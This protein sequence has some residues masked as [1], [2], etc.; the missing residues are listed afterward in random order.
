VNGDKDFT[1]VSPQFTV[2]Y[3]VA[4]GQTV[5]GTAA[6][7][8]KAG[9]FNAASPAGSEGYGEEHSWNYEGGFKS[10]WLGQRLALNGAVFYLNW[11]D[12]QVNLPNPQ[13]PGQ[14]YIANAGQ[15]TS[16]GLEFEVTARPHPGLDVFGGVGYT[17]ARFGAGSV[18]SGVKVDGNRLSNTPTYTADAGVQYSRAVSSAA[19]VY[20]RAE[21]VSYGDSQYDDANTTGQS[22][23]AL[24]N[25]R[26]GVRG[27]VVFAEL[28]V[29]N[30]ANTRYVPTAFAYDPRL[31]P[32]G[33]IGESGTPRV[34]GVRAGLTF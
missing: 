10:S 23:Y 8:F 11:R 17:N 28:W 13:V 29:R 34:F 6:R 15:A 24:T 16:K 21:V 19:T 25:L 2:A 12:L 20:G 4:P 1:D 27:K 31:A 5:Y 3:R 30:A 33:F 7:G 14:F 18:S 22:A 32:S 26:G 9:G